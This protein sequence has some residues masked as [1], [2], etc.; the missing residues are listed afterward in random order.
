MGYVPFFGE[1]EINDCSPKLYIIYTDSLFATVEDCPFPKRHPQTT[2]TITFSEDGLTMGAKCSKPCGA[3][4]DVKELEYI[5]AL[6]QSGLDGLRSD[7]SILGAY[8]EILPTC[9]SCTGP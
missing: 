4:A 9:Q 8:N 7:G 6:H 3:I 5:S 2:R 1:K